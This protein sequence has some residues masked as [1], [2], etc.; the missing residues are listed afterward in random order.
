MHIDNQ[1][2]VVITPRE[3]QAALDRPAWL[4]NDVWLARTPWAFP[5]YDGYCEFMAFLA[6]RLN[7]H[8]R[9]ILVR[10]S[11]KIGFSIS[12]KADKVWMAMR[13]DSDLDLAIVDTDYYHYFDREIRSY[14]RKPGNTP[15]RG[16]AAR[17]AFGRKK[18]RSFYTYRYHQFPDIAC[19]AEH[20]S[21]LSEAPVE[22]CCDALRSIS[23]FIYRDWWSVYSRCEYD[24]KD[25]RKA[26]TTPGFPMGTDVPRTAPFLLSAKDEIH[27][28]ERAEVTERKCDR[29][30]GDLQL[31]SDRQRYLCP[32]CDP[33]P[34]E[35]P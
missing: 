7:V 1:G 6:D 13:P 17:K 9:N 25:L 21:C 23:A 5:T 18:S 26:L 16:E 27:A 14:E 20:N 33:A 31:A 12:P 4:I 2:H 10:G 28:T 3:F 30:G 34:E 24:L 22:K 19:V 35:A 29:C 8:P 32:R 15:L 11:T